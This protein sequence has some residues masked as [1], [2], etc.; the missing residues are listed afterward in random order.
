MAL[1]DLGYLEEDCFKGK[2]F[3]IGNENG[4]D[5]TFIKIEDGKIYKYGYGKKGGKHIYPLTE[6]ECFGCAKILMEG[7]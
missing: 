7:K 3:K 5:Y 1:E 4:G 2:Y 6:K